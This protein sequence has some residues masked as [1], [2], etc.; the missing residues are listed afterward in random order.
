M[1]YNDEYKQCPIMMNTNNVTLQNNNH[2]LWFLRKY[3]IKKIADISANHALLERWSGQSQYIFQA[4]ARHNDHGKKF[5]LVKYHIFWKKKKR[6]FGHTS[7]RFWWSLTLNG[8]CFNFWWCYMSSYDKMST[9]YY[10]TLLGRGFFGFS[11][12]T[13]PLTGHV[14]HLSAS[15]QNFGQEIIEI[16]WWMMASARALFKEK[17]KWP[18]RLL[19][20][21]S[22]TLDWSLVLVVWSGT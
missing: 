19:S 18:G 21:W 8:P 5:P 3:W 14:Y 4:V 11:R 20:I 10:I 1:S 12:L 6:W 9:I 7:A 2:E 15:I 13:R 17:Q 22:H 16:I